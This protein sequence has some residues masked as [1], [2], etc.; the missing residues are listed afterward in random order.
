MWYWVRDIKMQIY[1]RLKMPQVYLVLLFPHLTYT[2]NDN[3][4]VEENGK[5]NE[6]EFYMRP[7][8]C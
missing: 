4:I 1:D 6:K 5:E 2:V 8:Y 3:K 7:T